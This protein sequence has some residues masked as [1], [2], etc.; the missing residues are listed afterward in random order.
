MATPSFLE[1]LG[2]VYE[3]RNETDQACSNYAAVL[4]RWGKATPPSVTAT[5]AR[6]R[7]R[8]LACPG[9][10]PLAPRSTGASPDRELTER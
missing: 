9:T 1:E 4:A 5:R 7:Q 6:A 8:A 10:M 2:R 3:T